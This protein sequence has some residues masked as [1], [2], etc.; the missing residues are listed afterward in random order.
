MRPQNAPE[1]RIRQFAQLIH[2]SEFL[3]SELMQAKD[4][5]TMVNILQFRSDD[6]NNLLTLPPKLGRKS[7]DI[8]LINTII[9]YQYAYA[10]AQHKTGIDIDNIIEFINQIPAEDNRIIKQWRTLGQHIQSAA[11]TQ[12]L[13]HLYQN[14]C[15]PHQCYN[16]Q[17]GYQIFAQQQ[18]SLF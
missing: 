16:C 2:Q 3:F 1:I 5:A 15:Q 8:L 17:V 13:L 18:L 9:P 10:L 4:I 6:T 14:Y 11:D 12:A 7:I